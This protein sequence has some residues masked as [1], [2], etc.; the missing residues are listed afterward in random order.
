METRYATDL[1]VIDDSIA[2][3][4]K[5]QID[6]ETRYNSYDIHPNG[7]IN[8][9]KSVGAKKRGETGT[10]MPGPGGGSQGASRMGRGSYRP[11]PWRPLAWRGPVTAAGTADIAASVASVAVDLFVAVLEREP[12]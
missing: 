2:V 12:K 11:R 10:K 5:V 3:E 1:L 4:E 6:V 9:E 7:E 8:V